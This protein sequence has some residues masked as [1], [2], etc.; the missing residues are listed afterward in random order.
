MDVTFAIQQAI[1]EAS[2]KRI[3]FHDYMAYA[4]YAKEGGYYEQKKQKI[5]KEGDFYTNASVGS[6]YGEVVADVLCE[7]LGKLSHHT[8]VL[9]E[10][11]GGTGQL[12][13]QILHRLQKKGWLEEQAPSCIY[14]MIEASEYHRSIQQEVL[15]SFQGS[16]KLE[17]YESIDEAKKAYP[18]LYG[19]LFSNELPDAFPVHLIEYREGR[20]QEVYVA[21]SETGGA[22]ASF[23]ERLGPLSD[24]GL[25]EYIKKESIPPIEGY[26]TEV[27]LNSLKWL[28][29]AG[30][31]LKEGYILTIDYGYERSALYAPSRRRGTL[32]CYRN[33][34]MSENPYEAPGEMDITSH[35]NFSALMDLGDQIDLTLLGFYTQQEF[36][37]QAG[38][39]E[40][41]VPH[42][43]GD[44]FRN[45][46]AKRNRAVRQL[47]MSEG[48]G[49]TFK[50]LL[51]GKQVDADLT[52]CKPW[53]PRM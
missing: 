30:Q 12:G 24:P 6:V 40:Y 25:S 50:V 48:M 3:T 8:P 7:M 15:A 20:W 44:P 41:L 33:H 32:L 21:E 19:V 16:V 52:C 53:K 4:L 43:G 29:E 1:R 23:V 28:R 2:Q 37:M 17:W 13:A 51:Q 42:E 14:I 39:L 38:M 36:L 46:S 49:R 11:G 18:E 31:W 47:I 34:R 9:V 45:E 10:M 22:Y 35:V 27:N 5:G 26:R